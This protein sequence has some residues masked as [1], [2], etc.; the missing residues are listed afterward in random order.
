MKRIVILALFT[1]ASSSN[2]ILV[3]D[4]RTYLLFNYLFNYGIG[5]KEIKTVDPL[6]YPKDTMKHMFRFDCRPG[7]TIYDFQSNQDLGIFLDQLLSTSPGSYA[8]LWV[9]VNNLA[10]Q[11]GII[12]TFNRYLG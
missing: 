1:F 11:Q 7:A 3:G 4:S 6:P 9:G 12:D 10:S 2:V 5:D 8:F